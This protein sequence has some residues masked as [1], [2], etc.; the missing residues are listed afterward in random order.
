MAPFLVGLL[1]AAEPSGRL[2]DSHV[3]AGAGVL[4]S[5]YTVF[6]SRLGDAA[7]TPMLTARGVFSGF[8]VDGGVLVTA[9]LSRGGTLFSLT[10]TARVGWSGER[11]SLVGG[12]V[13]QLAS[14][15][16]PSTQFLPSLRAQLSF[17]KAGLALGVF[18]VVGQVPLHL[19]VELGPFANGRFSIGWV[20]PVGLIAS[21]EVWM[22][23]DFGLRFFGFG[24][25]LGNVESAMGVVSL[26]YGGAR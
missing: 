23:R 19:S 17:G 18:D 2:L 12:L 5:S 14:E 25:R 21:V 9:P 22:T 20:A 6:G 4:G 10:G 8:V 13:A 26:V 11:W 3:A 16:T 7:F 1:L 15:A 24:S